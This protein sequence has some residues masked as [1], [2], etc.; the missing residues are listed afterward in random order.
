MLGQY[1]F[2]PR[3]G[4]AFQMLERFDLPIEVWVATGENLWNEIRNAQVV[5]PGDERF[6]LVQE[7][8]W[9]ARKLDGDMLKIFLDDDE[10]EI[11][12]SNFDNFVRAYFENSD[13]VEGVPME[14]RN[15]LAECLTSTGG[16][17]DL[18]REIERFRAFEE[19][20]LTEIAFRLHD[21]PMNALK[22]IGERVVDQLR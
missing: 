6:R 9:R 18:D 8:P 1:A 22:I 16:L 17:E 15:K 14:L 11:I 21:D 13:D 20:G 7:L 12:A 10:V 3:C 19:A 4:Y 5:V 2:K